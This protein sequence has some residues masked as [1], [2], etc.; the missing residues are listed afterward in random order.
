VRFECDF[1]GPAL[2]D[3]RPVLMSFLHIHAASLGSSKSWF[4][5]FGTSDSHVSRSGQKEF[6][7]IYRLV[8]LA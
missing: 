6:N 1:L 4:L 5:A 7:K 2:G 8:N 3:M